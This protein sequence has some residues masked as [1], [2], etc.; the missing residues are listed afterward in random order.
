VERNNMYKNGIPQFDGQKYAFWSRRMKTYIQAQGFEIWQLVVDGYKEP[1][2]PP[3]NERAM[4]LGKTNSKETN[5]FLNG[6][7]ELVYTKVIHC[8][9]AKGIWDKV[10]NIYEGDSKVNLAKLQTYRG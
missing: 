6:L 3:T 2:I 5:A 7:C 1:T 4:K 10:Q 9:S 8:K